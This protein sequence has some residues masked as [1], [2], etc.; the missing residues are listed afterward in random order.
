VNRRLAALALVCSLAAGCDRLDREGMVLVLDPAVTAEIVL[1]NDAGIASPDGLLWSEGTLYIADEGGSAVRAWRPGEPVRTLADRSDGLASPEDLVRDT[2][3]NIY[4]S[5]DDAGGVRR[6]APNGRVSVLP[7]TSQIAS[8]EGL[9]RSAGGMLMVGD[10]QSRQVW[11][12]QPDGPARITIPADG[13]IS[14]PET[15]AFDPE[16]NLYIGDNLDSVLYLQRADGTLAKVVS[17]REDFFPESLTVN[18][19]GL[20]ITDSEHGKVY[21]YT[22]DEG[23]VTIATFGGTLANV[24]G[25]TSDPSGNLYLSVQTDLKNRRGYILRLIH[26]AGPVAMTARQ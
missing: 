15:F 24:Q 10:Q 11:A 3:G 23:L 21:R 4:V 9:A 14:K 22:R 6:I 12:L 17:D 8:S 25:I 20:F 26:A 1:D 2:A 18:A 7:G 13:G 16:G 19:R 5:D